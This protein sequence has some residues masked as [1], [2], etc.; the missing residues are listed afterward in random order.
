MNWNLKLHCT[1][2]IF[3]IFL[4]HKVE[5]RAKV[6]LERFEV[7]TITD[8]LYTN[9]KLVGTTLNLTFFLLKTDVQ[10]RGT[11]IAV[12]WHLLACAQTI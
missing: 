4:L 7:A 5:P 3:G 11:Q 6:Y 9:K 12:S 8:E 1:W 2:E 10:F